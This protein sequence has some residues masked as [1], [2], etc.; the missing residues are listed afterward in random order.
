MSIEN[1]RKRR[2]NSNNSAS[3]GV[4][5]PISKKLNS[6][7][8]SV[9]SDV[10]P[11]PVTSAGLASSVSMASMTSASAASMASSG[12]QILDNPLRPP[13]SLATPPVVAPLT[14]MGQ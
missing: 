14:P 12:G 2:H 7:T 4:S 10:K 6:G 11:T 5:T 8:G 13:F 9:I 3:G 1:N